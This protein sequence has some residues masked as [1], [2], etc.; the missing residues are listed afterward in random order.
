MNDFRN[1][2]K[3]MLVQLVLTKLRA[4]DTRKKNQGKEEEEVLI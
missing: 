2:V 1:D 3:E 4:R